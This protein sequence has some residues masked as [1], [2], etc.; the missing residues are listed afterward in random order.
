MIS[1]GRFRRNGARKKAVV[2]S[3]E[4]KI[5]ETS[6]VQPDDR[7]ETRTGKPSRDST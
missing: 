3:G 5:Q 7:K 2:I 4:Q 6:E 1:E